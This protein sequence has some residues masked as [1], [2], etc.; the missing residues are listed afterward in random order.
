VS[1]GDRL[2]N[3]QQGPACRP[4]RAGCIHREAAEFV[5]QLSER[6]LFVKTLHPRPLGSKHSVAFILKKKIVR[7]EAQVLYAYG[8][9]EGPSKDP[10]MG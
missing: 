8:F 1:S 7:V 3:K 6:G 10:G 5:N 9:E 4:G 2:R